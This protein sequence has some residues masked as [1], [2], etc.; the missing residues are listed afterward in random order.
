MGDLLR[1]TVRQRILP[2]DVE[3][4]L[5]TNIVF[6]LSAL[7]SDIFLSM[8]FEFGASRFDSQFDDLGRR[9]LDELMPAFR[10]MLD[11]ACENIDLGVVEREL[12]ELPNEVK[13]AFAGQKDVLRLALLTALLFLYGNFW[14]V[15]A[16]LLGRKVQPFLRRPDNV[17]Q[18]T[19]A[20]PQ[21]K[22]RSFNI[23]EAMGRF[24][25]D[26]LFGG[27]GRSGV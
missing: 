13:L 19:D 24:D 16:R 17:Q 25:P 21:K 27:Q 3:R 22:E 5:I 6:F 9:E 15:Q 20:A 12:N 2:E 1:E 11:E 8:G 4:G 14:S 26:E 18:V 23:F 7:M 10:S